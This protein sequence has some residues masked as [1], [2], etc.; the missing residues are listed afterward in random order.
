VRYYPPAVVAATWGRVVEAGFGDDELAAAYFAYL[1]RLQEFRR[2][3]QMRAA[4]LGKRG[5]EYPASNLLVNGSFAVEPLAEPLEWRIGSVSRQF[6]TVRENRAVRI[7]FFGTGNVRYEHLSQVAILPQAGYY[8]LTMR[9]KTAGI[10]TN[11]GLRLEVPELGLASEPVCHTNDWTTV[12]LDLAVNQAQ[13]IR[14]AV[15]RR[16][17][18]KF[19]NKIEGSAWI[20]G[21]RLWDL[22]A[23]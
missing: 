18:R 7:Q 15:V 17:S 2:A 4:W 5:G 13:A 22:G 12:S 16:M 8:R 19:D 20:S 10:T 23:R 14:V 3:H 6:E 9:I 1:L 11:E 21:M